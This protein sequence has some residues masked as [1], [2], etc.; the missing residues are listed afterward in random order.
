[1]I[2]EGAMFASEIDLCSVLGERRKRRV[3]VILYRVA[4][5]W[6]DK[7]SVGRVSS[8]RNRYYGLDKK[9]PEGQLPG[10]DIS[11]CTGRFAKP[12]AGLI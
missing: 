2:S 5:H 10:A 8:E 3:L 7:Q 11:L 1:M 4:I 12:S 9:E 6:K